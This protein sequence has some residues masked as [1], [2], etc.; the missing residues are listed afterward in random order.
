MN[1]YTRIKSLFERKP[2]LQ[3]TFTPETP[4][5]RAK[6]IARPWWEQPHADEAK[7][8]IHDEAVRRG[9]PSPFQLDEHG[10]H[11]N[12][13]GSGWFIEFPRYV[14]MLIRDEGIECATKYVNR[15]YDQ[16]DVR[17]AMDK[18]MKANPNENPCVV[19]YG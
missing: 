9:K 15:A 12:Y 1:I 5:Q 13:Y 18:V 8:L 10:Y 2:A 14:A 4:E 19:S 7:K 3:I 6:V 16:G 17:E 11:G